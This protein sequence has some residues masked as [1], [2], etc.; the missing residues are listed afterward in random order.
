MSN[1][2]KFFPFLILLIVLGFSMPGQKPSEVPQSVKEK[3]PTSRDAFVKVLDITIEKQSEYNSIDVGMNYSALVFEFPD[4]A[5][6][7]KTRF[8]NQKGDSFPVYIITGHDPDEPLRSPLYVS[9]SLSDKFTLISGEFAGKFRLYLIGCPLLKLS[10]HDHLSKGHIDCQKPS[11]IPSY[12]WREGLAD[13]IS[14][15]TKHE[16][17]H[18]VIHHSA[19]SNTAKNYTN[20]VRNIYLYH[21]EVNG[22]DDVGYNYLVAPD[23]TIFQGRDDEGLGEE[24][25]IKGAHFCGKNSGTMG[26]CMLG[27]FMNDFPSD[28][29]LNSLESLLSWKAFKEQM[30]VMGKSRHP[31]QSSPFLEHICGHRDGCATACPGDSAFTVLNKLR[32]NVQLKLD[33]C[34]Q[35]VGLQEMALSEFKLY[36]NPNRGNIY[37]KSDYDLN[38][39]KVELFSVTGRVLLNEKISDSKVSFDDSIENGVYYLKL[40]SEEQLMHFSRRIVIWR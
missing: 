33:S 10:E 15:R 1:F 40:S 14:G 29:C 28:S 24:D 8:Y 39:W 35:H 16:V 3:Y 23:G 22:W 36:P 9:D 34:N 11:Y 31:D 27:N 6:L 19:T 7:S 12:E 18:I 25:N 26:I 20:V 13:P 5:D 2:S 38:D 17:N 30:D 37:I 32:S 4:H 21:T